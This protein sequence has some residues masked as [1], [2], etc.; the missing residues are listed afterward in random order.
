[1]LVVSPHGKAVDRTLTQ[2][3]PKLTVEV[4]QR[5]TARD[6]YVR[7]IA[8]A[9]TEMAKQKPN[10]AHLKKILQVSWIFLSTPANLYV[11]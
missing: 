7:N 3:L 5:E 1:M 10:K 2:P 6:D 8:E 4:A 9:R 11:H